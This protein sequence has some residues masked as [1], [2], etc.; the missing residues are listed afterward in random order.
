MVPNLAD[1]HAC[2]LYCGAGVISLA[3]ARQAQ[4][5]TG[6]EIVADSV[7]SA[8]ENATRNGIENCRFICG[9]AL[10]MLEQLE[11]KPDFFS[12]DPPRMG[13]HPKALRKII[14]FDL[15]ELL[16]ISCNP[17]SFSE[18][19]A[20]L[21]ENGYKVDGLRVYDNFPFTKHVECV[22]LLVKR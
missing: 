2:D 15:P 10:E 1:K 16:Y 12:V 8:R 20:V 3:L 19:A 4:A 5:V 13:M 9:D 22:G 6:I 18:N 11:R 14:S 7:D 17:R 21:Q